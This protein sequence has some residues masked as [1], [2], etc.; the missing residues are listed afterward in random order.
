ML[1]ARVP[2]H[3]LV[4]RLAAREKTQK[5]F[6]TKESGAFIAAIVSMRLTATDKQSRPP[7]LSVWDRAIAPKAWLTDTLK[8]PRDT[9]SFSARVEAVEQIDKLEVSYDSDVDPRVAGHPETSGH[10][11]IVGL[12]AGSDA[13]YRE[14]REQ[15]IDCFEYDT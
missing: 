13:E 9:E 6:V 15:L 4:Y 10:A 7:R 11:G 2:S 5:G 8:R 1:G 3:H 12:E 14:R